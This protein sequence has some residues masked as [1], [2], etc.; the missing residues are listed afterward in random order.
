MKETRGVKQDFLKDNEYHKIISKLWK[1]EEKYILRALEVTLLFVT[2]PVI[3]TINLICFFI[4]KHQIIVD[5]KATIMKKMSFNN[6][7]FSLTVTALT[8]NLKFKYNSE[9]PEQFAGP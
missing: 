1:G 7:H 9:K 5:F 6:W 4:K 2:F 8:E 3:Y